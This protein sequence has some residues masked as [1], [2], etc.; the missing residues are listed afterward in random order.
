MLKGNCDKRL[1]KHHSIY[2]ESGHEVESTPKKA[3]KEYL[4]T[5]R[6]EPPQAGEHSSTS[7]REE[8]INSFDRLYYCSPIFALSGES[9]PSLLT[10][11]KLGHY[12]SGPIKCELKCQE[13]GGKKLLKPVCTSPSPGSQ[14]GQQE[15]APQPM[16]TKITFVVVCH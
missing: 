9:Y 12:L 6:Q 4:F 3:L 1:R 14:F 8:G 16:N 13:T 2:Q 7:N 15:A 10:N 5:Q 11:V